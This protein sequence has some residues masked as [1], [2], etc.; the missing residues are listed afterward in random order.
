MGKHLGKERLKYNVVRLRVAGYTMRQI[1]DRVGINKATAVRWTRE[2]A[3]RIEATRVKK[4]EKFG[5][6]IEDLL[7]T[8]YVGR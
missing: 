1:A 2:M 4:L 7:L 8:P 3:E 5:K 6:F